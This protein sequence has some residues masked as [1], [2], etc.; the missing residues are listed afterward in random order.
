MT[1]PEKPGSFRTFCRTLGKRAVTEFN[2][3]Y[4]DASL[5]RVYVGV[6][7]VPNGDRSELI[8]SLSKAGYP[9][10][11]MTDNELAKM[12]VRHM[13]GGRVS[14]GKSEILYRFEFPERPGALLKFLLELGERWNITMF[15]YRNH[16][17]AWGRVLIGFEA[18][19]EVHAANSVAFSIAS[20]TV[21]R[22]RPITRR[23]RCSCV[24]CDASASCLSTSN[25]TSRCGVSRTKR[26][27]ARRVCT[28]S[29][30]TTKTQFRS[31]R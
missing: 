17:A 26:R 1:I 7:I 23:T 29:T 16:G 19:R 9:V 24:D 6:Q 11:D 27:V 13:V 12:H 3:R 10:E 21:I 14:S 28:R 22:K 25:S 2:Y 30:T 31:S 8:S 5:A 4:A 18:G 15:H 20:A